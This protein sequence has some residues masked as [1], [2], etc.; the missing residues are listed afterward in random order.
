MALDRALADPDPDLEQL[1]ADPLSTPQPVFFSHFLEQSN[2]L[3][4]NLRFTALMFGL[5]S[6]IS[7]EEIAM[8]TQEGLRLDQMKRLASK[9]GSSAPGESARSDHPS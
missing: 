9:T 2:R 7:T 8:P 4:G 5:S 6:P 3:H 1:A